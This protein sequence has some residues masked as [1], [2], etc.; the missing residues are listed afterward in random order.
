MIG[1]AYK[2]VPRYL[3]SSAFAAFITNIHY[4]AARQE[5]TIH[6]LVTLLSTPRLLLENNV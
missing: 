3:R 4:T 6:H 5:V 2:T 1:I